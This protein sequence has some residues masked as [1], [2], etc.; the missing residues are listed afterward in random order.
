MMAYPNPS[1]IEAGFIAQAVRALLELRRLATSQRD[2]LRPLMQGEFDF[3]SASLSQQFQ[4]VRDHLSQVIETVN[5][6]RTKGVR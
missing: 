2:L 6:S 1:P 5:G 3:I 4:Q